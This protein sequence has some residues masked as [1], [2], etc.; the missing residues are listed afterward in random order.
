MI[1]SLFTRLDGK[2]WGYVLT[3]PGTD[4]ERHHATNLYKT[5]GEPFP[6]QQAAL[7]W[8]RRRDWFVPDGFGKTTADA[9]RACGIDAERRPT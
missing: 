2:A 6:G 8:E 4:P 3:T 7:A 9:M 1:L 5:Q